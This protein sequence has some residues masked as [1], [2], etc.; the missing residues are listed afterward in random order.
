MRNKLNVEL[1]WS[2]K[3]KTRPQIRH[4]SL[5]N[6]R[7]VV[8]EEFLICLKLFLLHQGVFFCDD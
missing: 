8:A 4:L 6:K 3:G 7:S 2:G 1:S 5:I